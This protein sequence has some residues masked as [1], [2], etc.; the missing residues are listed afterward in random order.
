MNIKFPLLAILPIPD[1]ISVLST[2]Q[3]VKMEIGGIGRGINAGGK[4]RFCP[5]FNL[6]SLNNICFIKVPGSDRGL[7]K[8]CINSNNL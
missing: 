6:E 7:W 3:E 4:M 5:P 8:I 1:M 2:F